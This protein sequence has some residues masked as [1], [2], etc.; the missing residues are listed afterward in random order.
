MRT[1]RVFLGLCLAATAFCTRGAGQDA[2]NPAEPTLSPEQQLIRKHADAFV[3]AFN[4]ADARA[5]AALWTPTGE[6]SVDGENIAKGRK[7]IEKSYADYF[8][9]NPGQSIRVTIESINLLGPKMAVEKGRSEIVNDNNET[10]VDAYTLIHVKEGDKWLIASADV[11]QELIESESDWKTELAF[12]EGKWKAETDGW[13]VDT[14]FE[15]VA[16][17]NFLKRTFSVYNGEEVETTGVQVIGW[18]PINRSVTS[19]V[20]GSD[21]GHGRGWW[22]LDGIQ[23]VIDSESTTAGGEIVTATN[24]ITVLDQ[25]TFRW[26]STNRTIE[27]YELEDT[28]SIRVSRVKSEK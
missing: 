22:T 8:L 23:W 14:T 7:D 5:V 6:M 28:D 24:H 18:D 15:W 20:F 26:Q 16:G 1:H 12:L 3:E 10:V 21:G 4:N 11:Q 2:D 25:N 9:A 17:G 19:W 27:G 13:N